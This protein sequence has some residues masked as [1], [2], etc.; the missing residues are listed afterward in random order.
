MS[1][2]V[3]CAGDGEPAETSL[4]AFEQQHV[5]GTTL[6][7]KSLDPSFDVREEKLKEFSMPFDKSSL[8]DW[9]EEIMMTSDAM[10]LQYRLVGVLLNKMSA[11][12][13]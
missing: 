4:A 9:V 5:S 8:R 6:F 2:A 7:Q 13:A 1:L 3:V 11:K 10:P 12:R